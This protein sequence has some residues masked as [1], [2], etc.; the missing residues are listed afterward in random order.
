MKCTK[1]GR[2]GARVG[3]ISLGTMNFGPVIGEEGSFAIMDA[4][5]ENGVTFFDTADVYGGAPW[6]DQPG[7]SESIVGRWMADRGNRDNLVLATTVYGDMGA[8]ENDRVLSSLHIRAVVED[9]LKR[10]ATDRID[11]YQMHPGAQAHHLIGS[12][13]ADI[14]TRTLRRTG[15]TPAGGP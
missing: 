4:A 2:A 10:L 8:R 7:Q 9:S 12:R 15:P 6:G 14:L 5:V 3:R 11:M 13:F 1:L